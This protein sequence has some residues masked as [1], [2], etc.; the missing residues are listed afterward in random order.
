MSVCSWEIIN[1]S[2]KYT[3]QAADFA[4]AAAA[5]LL[6]GEGRYG[7]D[8]E[9]DGQPRC[10]LFLFGGHDDFI[11]EHFGGDLSAWI[12]AHVEAVAECLDSVL[13]G[14]FGRRRDY[15]AAVA[16]IDDPVKLAVF[17]EAWLDKRSSLNNIG[18]YAAQIA[19]GLRERAAEVTP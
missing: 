19:A 17:R 3:L 18:G 15:D 10:P 13:L 16:A 1:P 5:C 9:S 11:A 14:G 2:D 4:T 8:P 6:L 12:D 7:L